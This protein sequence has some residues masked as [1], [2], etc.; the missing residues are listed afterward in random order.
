MAPA[1]SMKTGYLWAAATGLN[2]RSIPTTP[3]R[4]TTPVRAERWDVAISGRANPHRFGP[5]ASYLN[6][7]EPQ[8]RFQTQRRVQ[9]PQARGPQ[10]YRFNWNT[11]FILSHHNSRIFYAAGN[12]VFRSLDRGNDLRTI[13]PNITRTDKGRRHRARRVAAQPR[14]VLRWDRRRCALGDEG[15]RRDLDRHCQERGFIQ[16]VLRGDDRAVTLPGGAG[17]CRVRRASLRYRRSA[18]LRHGGLR[19]NLEAI[20]GGVAPGS[21]HCLREDI[22]NADLLYLGTEFQFW[23]SLDRGQSWMSLNTNLPTVAIH[24]IALHPTAGELVAATHGRSLW[25]LDLTPLRQTTREVAKAAVHLYKPVSAVSWRYAPSHGG[26]TR[27][28]E[29]QNPAAAAMID[30]RAGQES[31]QGEPENPRR[32]WGCL[33]RAG[34]VGRPGIAPCPVEPVS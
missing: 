28:F 12:V 17:L 10:R 25:A 8:H 13:S 18:R 32:Q 34:C 22:K 14:G 23:V 29:G 27:R 5:A 15:R 9:S 24:D 20:A 31:Q 30:Y 4:S 6:E 19:R 7:A 1:R 3:T 26:T 21:S 11:P 33:E 16:A 2:A